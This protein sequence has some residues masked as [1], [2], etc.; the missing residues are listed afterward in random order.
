MAEWRRWVGG[1]APRRWLVVASV[2]ATTAV[3]AGVLVATRDGGVSAVRVAADGNSSDSS[4]G[5]TTAE[6]AQSDTTS[7]TA[8]TPSSPAVTTGQAPATTTGIVVRRNVGGNEAQGWTLVLA[9]HADGSTCLEFRVSTFTSG[10][11]LCGS[12]PAAA[13]AVVG[14]LVSF[15]TPIGRAIVAIVEPSVE[16][17]ALTPYLQQASP[18]I[19]DPLPGRDAYGYATGPMKGTWPNGASL[20]FGVEENVIARTRFAVVDG[21][22]RPGQSLTS[23]SKPYGTWPQYRR[24]GTTGFY[25]GGNEEVGMYDGAGGRCLLYRR[26]G[27]DPEA[28]LLDLCAPGDGEHPIAFAHLLPV[29]PEMRTGDSATRLLVVMADGLKVASWT[30]ETASEPRDCGRRTNVGPPSGFSRDSQILEDRSGSGRQVIGHF[31][32]PLYFPTAKT[33][34]IIL[35]DAS[36]REVGRVTLDT[37]N[38]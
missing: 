38:G 20:Y 34:T 11:L 13:G 28:V 37:G 22:I 19:R 33:A 36:D 9:E 12:G 35:R 17:W 15:E 3:V 7:S 6:P 10:S 2:V 27:G 31:P 21:T 29:P 23:T 25:W 16:G 4:P 14:D 26:L 1:V 8:P 5:P 32:N 18:V 24:A 30:C